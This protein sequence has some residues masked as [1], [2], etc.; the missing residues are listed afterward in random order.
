VEAFRQRKLDDDDAS[1]PFHMMPASLNLIADHNLFVAD[2]RAQLDNDAPPAVVVIDTLNRSLVGSENDDKDMAAYIRASDAIRDS[3]GCLVVIIHHCGHNGERP[4]GH[5]SLIGALDVQVAVWRDKSTNN[6][7]AELEHNKDGETGL[8]LVSRLEVVEI[9]LDED[10]DA[11]TSLVVVPLED[12]APS[13]Q[14]VEKAPRPPA[15]S[16]RLLFECIHQAIDDNGEQFRPYPNGPN[17]KG[18][19]DDYV[20]RAYYSRIAEKALPDE[21]EN[22]LEARKQKSFVRAVKS[23]LDAKNL[24]AIERNNSRFVW[25]P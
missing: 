6:V 19:D 11:I 21:D 22:K 3:F 15:T 16:L 2:V 8:K 12:A 17:V 1:P 14:S 5:S 4:R 23:A 20:R 18:V 24:L 10:G 9:G 13:K 7:V 25:F